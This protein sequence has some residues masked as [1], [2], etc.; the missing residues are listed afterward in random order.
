MSKLDF[1]KNRSSILVDNNS[2]TLNKLEEIQNATYNDMVRLVNK[3]GN[4]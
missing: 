1:I 3:Y 4:R 2:T